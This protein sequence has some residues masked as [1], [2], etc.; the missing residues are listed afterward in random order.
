MTS[1]FMTFITNLNKT[2]PTLMDMTEIRNERSQLLNY[3]WDFQNK[4]GYISTSDITQLSAELG[5]SWIEIEGVIS[6]YHFLNENQPGNIIS[7]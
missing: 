1:P 3:L 7:I 5:I 6:F 4:K 2:K